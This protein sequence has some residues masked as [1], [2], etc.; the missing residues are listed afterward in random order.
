[1][2]NVNARGNQ[3]ASKPEILKPFCGSKVRQK[4]R[5]LAFG[6]QKQK[7]SRNYW[8]PGENWGLDSPRNQSQSFTKT[9]FIMDTSNTPSNQSGNTPIWSTILRYGSYTA[10]A[11]VVFSLLTY[12]VNFNMMSFSGIAVLYGSILIIGFVLASMAIRYQRDQLDGGYISYGKAL[13][14]GSLTVLL[15]MFLSGFWN[16]VLINFIDPNYVN[17]LKE[18]F[19]ETWG[20]SMPPEALEQA[21]EGFDKSGEL[22]STLKSSLMGGVIFGLI[23][24]LITAAF[25][26][27]QPEMNIR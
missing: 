7:N 21:L 17:T 3:Q 24:G 26:K 14:V 23:V 9:R 10:G 4:P 16:Y 27:K 20:G 19:L 22:L 2:E 8:R 25:M 18:Q 12:L 5:S 1:M 13:L 6:R 15:G 11:F